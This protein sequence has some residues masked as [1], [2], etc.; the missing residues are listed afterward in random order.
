MLKLVKT[1]VSGNT[2]LGAKTTKQFEEMII[3]KLSMFF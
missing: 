2:H 3:V 1:M